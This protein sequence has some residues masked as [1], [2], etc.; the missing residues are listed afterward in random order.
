MKNTVQIDIPVASAE[1]CEIL[2]A[3]LSEIDFYAFQ[4]NQNILSAYIKEEH[5]D[6]ELLI[7]NLKDICNH[8][9]KIIIPDTNWNQKW[10]DEFTPVVIQDFVAVRAAFHQPVK[11]VKHEIIITPKM[12]FG[13]GHHATT[14]L[15]LKQMKAIDFNNTKVLDFGT[16]S[17]ILAIMAKKLGA[18]AVTAVDN[19]DWSITN[20]RENL[21][22]NNC[23]EISL[24]KKDSVNN[25]G[26]FDIILTNINLNVITANIEGLTQASHASTILVLSGFLRSDFEKLVAVMEKDFLCET[27]SQKDDWICIKLQRT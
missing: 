20:V 23:E 8:Y 14:Y 27:L 22:Y 21:N 2:T 26:I 13:T 7:S 24:I 25:L 10:E 3:T 4:E 11:R 15:M 18:K 16:G 19:D 5:F 6:E 17:G 9:T 12:S 1:K